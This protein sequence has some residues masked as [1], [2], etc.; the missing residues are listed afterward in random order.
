MGT[1]HVWIKASDLAEYAQL[2]GTSTQAFVDL[3]V[4]QVGERL[5]LR[6]RADGR[7]IL[8][9]GQNRCSIYQQR[10]EQCRSFP[11]WPELLDDPQA[12]HRAAQY[13][14]GIQRFPDPEMAL[15]VLPQV[16][17][18][19]DALLQRQEHELVER[20]EAGETVRWANSL[21]IDLFLASGVE[22]HIFDPQLLVELGQQLQNLAS[23]SG[24][25]WSSAAW[26]RLLA[27]RKEGWAERGGLPPL[28]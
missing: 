17:Q 14:P 6:E 11:Y 4:K 5:S 24:Y 3:N 27:D 23:D 28:S 8:L 16:A 26:P 7:C 12:L 19:L 1:G 15:Q 21:E 10:P 22:R 18:V 9:D 20:T 25:P 2:T 13:C